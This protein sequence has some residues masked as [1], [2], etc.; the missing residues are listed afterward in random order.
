MTVRRCREPRGA[1]MASWRRLSLLNILETC[2]YFFWWLVGTNGSKLRANKY[3]S[4]IFK[5]FDRKKIFLG[6]KITERCI[7]FDEIRTVISLQGFLLACRGY[8]ILRRDTTCQNQWSNWKKKGEKNSISRR[9]S[10]QKTK[11]LNL[12]H[13]LKWWNF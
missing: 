12:R 4:R 2:T 3:S 6:I 1:L 8:F 11:I 7:K 9:F 5:N 10:L 13:I